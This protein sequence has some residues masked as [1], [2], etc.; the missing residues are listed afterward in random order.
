MGDRAGLAAVK[1]KLTMAYPCLEIYKGSGFVVVE[2]GNIIII[3][4]YFPPKRQMS[5]YNKTLEDLET[6][7]RNL[8]GSPMI[9]AGDFNARLKLWDPMITTDTRRGKLLWE[10]MSALGSCLINTGDTP[11]CIRNRGQSVVDLTWS[12]PDL[13]DRIR[14]W[15]VEIGE[16]S[17]SDHRYVSFAVYPPRALNLNLGLGASLKGPPKWIW[18]KFCKDRFA[19]AL[20]IKGWTSMD[21]DSMEVEDLAMEL[22]S[23]MKQAC[24][25][26]TP[27]AASDG[28][29]KGAY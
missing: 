4:C 18:A 29:R 7:I 17:L 27:R 9:M 25:L 20:Y 1:W 8:K 23:R 10:L 13:V 21:M 22:R 11:T 24:D 16:E 6:C 5:E 19:A 15:K 26:A 2:C 28:G 3:S 14:E 12:S